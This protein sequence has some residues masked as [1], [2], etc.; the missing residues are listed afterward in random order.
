MR[1]PTA[2]TRS[3]A[4]PSAQTPSASRPRLPAAYGVPAGARDLLPWSH[5]VA[6]MQMAPH[7]WICTVD[8]AGHPHA[9][10]VDGLWLNDRL[11]FGGSP[12][13]RRNRNLAA[14]PHVCVHL[15]SASDV[16]MLQGTAALL[17]PDRALATR[18]ADASREKYG[19]APPP[20]DYEAMG[21]HVFRPQLVFAWQRFPT[22]MTRWRFEDA[23]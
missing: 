4:P 2:R 13:T 21:V 8:P 22:D 20:G 14:N 7:Y 9:V 15:E 18:L 6:R 5:V 11:Y 19:Y 10:P 1:R 16:V 23:G 3:A 17:T 12:A